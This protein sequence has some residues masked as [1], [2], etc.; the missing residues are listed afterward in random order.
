M[1][2]PP[3]QIRLIKKKKVKNILSISSILVF[4]FFANVLLHAQGDTV[5]LS[6]N[7]KFKDGVFMTFEDFK[8]NKPTYTWKDVDAGVHS[9]PQNFTAQMYY[10][11]VKNTSANGQKTAGQ[12]TNISPSENEN[13]LIDLAQVWGIALDGIPYIR[14]PKE[15]LN[16]QN[17]VFVGLKLR[18]KISYFEYAEFVMKKIRMSAYNP[19]TGEPFRTMDVEREVQVTHKKMLDF[20]SGEIADFTTSNFEKWIQDDVALL[21]TVKDLPDGKANQKLFKCLLIYVDR[22][23]VKITK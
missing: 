3:T 18:G 12:N 15:A 5:Y 20:T 13:S 6:K 11:K 14:L 4:L 22:N 10:L 7:F 17:T 19:R 1:F 8:N 16:K 9:N 21:E 23:L 2:N